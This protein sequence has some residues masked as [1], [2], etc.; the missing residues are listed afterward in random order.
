MAMRDVAAGGRDR[1]DSLEEL[2]SVSGM[3]ASNEMV[4]EAIAAGRAAVKLGMES[5]LRLLRSPKN[6]KEV[7]YMACDPSYGSASPWDTR[8]YGLRVFRLTLAQGA[9]I[10][11]AKDIV[12]I[13]SPLDTPSGLGRGYFFPGGR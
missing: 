12:S 8:I 1:Y 9:R 7:I 10:I 13:F 5:R 4:D 3:G 2:Y 6:A 11:E